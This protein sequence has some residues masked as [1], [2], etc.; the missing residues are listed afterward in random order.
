MKAA[1]V[2]VTWLERGDCS[3][4]SANIFYAMI[5]STNS[6]VRRLLNEK[7]LHEEEVQAMKEKFHHRMQGILRQR[8][9]LLC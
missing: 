3:K 6:H 2:L 5:Q 4:R 8:M 1:Q 9:Y 7:M